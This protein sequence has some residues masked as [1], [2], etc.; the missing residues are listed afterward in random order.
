MDWLGVAGGGGAPSTG[1]PACGCRG[2]GGISHEHALYLEGN[3]N[4]AH[5][6]ILSEAKLV[7]PKNERGFLHD[8]QERSESTLARGRLFASD[9]EHEKTEGTGVSIVL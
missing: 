8:T 3:S 1:G 7:F 5:S 4:P 2:W 6:I 9:S